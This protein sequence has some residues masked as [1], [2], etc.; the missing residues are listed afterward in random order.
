LNW[1]EWE[2]EPPYLKSNGYPN[3][4]KYIGPG[5]SCPFTN[6]A[7]GFT[8]TDRPATI[9]GAKSASTIPSSGTYSG[10]IC[11]SIDSGK[12]LAGKTDIYYNGCYTSVVDQVT[13]VSS[14]SEASCGTLLS[15]TCT[16]KN[17]NKVCKQ[18][19]YKHYW[20]DNPSDSNQAKNAAPAHSTW[21]G[22]VNDRDQNYDT[23]NDAMTGSGTP[24]KLIYPEQW[25][26]CLPATITAMS[27]Q[28][29]DLK[30]QI[31]NMTP[32][33]N[34]NQ[35]VGLFWGWQTLNTSNDPYKAPAKD[36]NWVYKDYIVV[37]SDGMNTQNRWSTSQ[38]AIDARQ[39][40]LCNNIKNPTLN[41]GNQITIFAIQ[42]NINNKDPESQVLKNCAKSPNPPYFQVINQSGQ[43]A[44]AFNSILAQIAKLRIS[45]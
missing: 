12:K 24:S 16:G 1:T 9:S 18:T 27:N 33:G 7:Y 38:S 45:K 34:T 15:C 32:S 19:S 2:A 41:G 23:T 13:T 30:T 20:R 22:C 21:T 31:S 8:C 28:W 25:S 5:E 10:M 11:P 42:V 6:N 4:W 26:D 17:N 29:G 37:L 36:A 3:N 39:A 35:A 14:G 44:D 43:T 40:T